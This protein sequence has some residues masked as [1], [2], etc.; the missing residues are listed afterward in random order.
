MFLNSVKKWIVRKKK[1]NRFTKEINTLSS[2]GMSNIYLKV[3]IE[4]KNS[5]LKKKIG[6]KNLSPGQILGSSNS[7]RCHWLLKLLVST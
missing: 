1:K 2:K 7:Q 5:K 3:T 6:L 4:E